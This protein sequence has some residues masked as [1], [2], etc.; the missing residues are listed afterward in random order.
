VD[1]EKRADNSK[2]HAKNRKWFNKNANLYIPAETVG[3]REIF[4][5]ACGP[6]ISATVINPGEGDVFAHRPI[7]LTIPANFRRAVI[8][9]DTLCLTKAG[10]LQETAL[11]LPGSP[12]QDGNIRASVDRLLL[13]EDFLGCGKVI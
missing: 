13:C 12:P 10:R 5:T 7:A 4:I 6:G 1:Q 3:P 9:P 2:N 8:C 11:M